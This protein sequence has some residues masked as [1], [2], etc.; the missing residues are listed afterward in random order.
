MTTQR[1]FLIEYLSA[2]ALDR[3]DGAAAELR[4]EGLAM[5][6]AL[7][8][9][10]AAMPNVALSVATDRADDPFDADDTSPT[11]R[12][13]ALPGEALSDFVARQSP[14]HDLVWVVAPETGGLLAALHE[15]VP[16]HRWI[17]C[18]GRAIRLASSKQATL[19]RL[20]AHGIKTPLDFAA[21]VAVRHWVVKPDDGA[22]S[23]R[24]RRH[25]DRSSAQADRQQREQRGETTS[26]EP[27]VD[28]D[29]MSLSLLVRGDGVDLLAVN[30]QRLAI[31]AGGAVSLSAVDIA[32]TDIDAVQHAALE[33]TA[34]AVCAAI[35]GLGGF[36][37]IDLVWHAEHGPVV[38]EVNPRV[39]SA[40][41]GMSAALGRNLAADIL[42][43]HTPAPFVNT[44]TDAH[45]H[46]TA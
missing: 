43:A 28:G 1:V 15:A 20:L 32:V 40:Y 37:G 19:A 36:V 13:C 30:R 42:A 25:G 5:R 21:G 41:V 22:G 4:A 45:A 29:A 35:P 23:V 38:I 44:A 12:V 11:H 8:D 18:D 16:S 27:W 9:D 14:L 17:G 3:R 7:R 6:E 10:L 46:T 39:T 24:T 26:L 31:N 2:S 34:R 33:Q